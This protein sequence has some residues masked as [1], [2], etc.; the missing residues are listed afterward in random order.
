M[1]PDNLGSPQFNPYQSG[2]PV[3]PAQTGFNQPQ[4][5]F[6]TTPTP[7]PIGPMV[8]GGKSGKWRLL[9]IIFIITTLI[10]AGFGAWAYINYL[11]QKSNVDGKI[12]TAVAEAVK[13]QADEDA[14]N[15]LEKEKQPNRQF[16][17]PD[18]YGHLTFDYPKT[19]SVYVSKD[20]STGGTFEAYLH[21]AVVPPLSIS[22]RYALRVS[23]E[24]QDYDKVVGGYTT[25]VS[26]GD[27]KSS[28]FK[29]DETN[30]GTRLDGNFT[31]DI[32]GS[33]VI[34]KIRDKTVTLQSDA[35]T[36]RADFDALIKT[37]AFNK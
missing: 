22:E 31:K 35:E 28:T 19:W 3:P 16:A 20:A 33:A 13:S 30:S 4:N 2:Q 36:F 23:I 7:S 21:P 29:I 9:A 24:E 27:L 26:R 32:R 14:A 11:D 1:N 17:G 8:V 6:T 18:D 25:L 12:S 15:F 37:I 10:A 34:F 5:P